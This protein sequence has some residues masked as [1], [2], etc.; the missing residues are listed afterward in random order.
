VDD[1]QD[2]WAG[3]ALI[4]P[5]HRVY[6]SGDTGLFPMMREIGARFGPFDLT[7]I[8]VGQYNRAWP[9]WHIGPEQAVRAHQL[10]RGRVLLPVHW[11][12]FTLAY[13][14]WTEPIERALAAAKSA[15]VAIVAPMP[16]QSIEPSKPPAVVRW[17]PK[18]PWRTGAQDPIVSSQN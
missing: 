15:G 2:L 12:T 5:Q 17:W 11:A 14:G 7:M 9:D 13:H 16:G 8:E 18:L 4:G 1:D 10:V 3:Y 6:Y